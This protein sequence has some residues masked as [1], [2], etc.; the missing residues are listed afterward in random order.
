M[1]MCHEIKW[2]QEK[3]RISRESKLEHDTVSCTNATRE[4]EKKEA[5]HEMVF[6]DLEVVCVLVICLLEVGTDKISLVYQPTSQ[7]VFYIKL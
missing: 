6:W 5:E 3:D 2:G 1:F 4:T 7:F